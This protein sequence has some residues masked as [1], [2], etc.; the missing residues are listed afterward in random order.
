MGLTLQFYLSNFSIDL[1]L[2][3]S[4][5]FSGLPNKVYLH[6]LAKPLTRLS[7]VM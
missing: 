2:S 3:R 7:G 1:L 4:G 6:S 5:I